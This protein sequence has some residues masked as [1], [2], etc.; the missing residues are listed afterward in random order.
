MT[1]F[2]CRIC[3]SKR[4]KE[5]EQEVGE[6]KPFREVAIQYLN[7]FG[8]DLHLLEQSIATH[9]KKHLTKNNF[10]KLTQEE[11][12]LLDRFKKG[13]VSLEEASRVVA[14]KVF[15]KMLR[16]PEDVRFVDFFRSELLKIKH[17]EV[18]DRN[19]HAMEVINRLFA[20]QLP[21]RH[22]PSCGYDVFKMASEPSPQNGIILADS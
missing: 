21:P 18:E 15:E 11:L 17:Q 2:N 7:S 13:E 14:V 6:G 4:R 3:K 8:V 19:V 20:G 5:I 12:K 9:Q 16:N 10:H 1:N 22:C